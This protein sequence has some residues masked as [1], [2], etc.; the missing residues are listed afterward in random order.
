MPRWLFEGDNIDPATWAALATIAGSEMLTTA[1][2][3]PR[4]K[5]EKN[6]ECSERQRKLQAALVSAGAKTEPI[7]R[8]TSKFLSRSSIAALTICRS[9]AVLLCFA[10]RLSTPSSIGKWDRISVSA[11]RRAVSRLQIFFGDYSK[12][13]SFASV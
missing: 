12:L 13:P 2:R 6:A 5:V 4:R 11:F 10:F 9:T 8:L 7:N 3:I 1:D